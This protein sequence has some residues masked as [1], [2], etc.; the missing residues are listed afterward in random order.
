[1]RSQTSFFGR[2]PFAPL[3]R[4]AS[5]LASLVACPPLRPSSTAAGFLRG[6]IAPPDRLTGVFVGMDHPAAFASND[7]PCQ[8]SRLT[9]LHGFTDGVRDLRGLLGGEERNRVAVP[10]AAG[11]RG[12]DREVAGLK[13]E[14]KGLFHT[15]R[16]P[17]SLGSVK[18]DGQ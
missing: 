13:C 8:P 12:A 18:V 7:L 9:G 14:R 15:R 11:I 17:N 5:D 16:I 1:M 2:P 3:A 4:A 10:C 6:A